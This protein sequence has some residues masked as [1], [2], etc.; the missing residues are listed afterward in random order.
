MVKCLF[1][2][3]FWD[4]ASQSFVPRNSSFTS[5]STNSFVWNGYELVFF[6]SSGGIFTEFVVVDDV[7]P[8]FTGLYYN[9]MQ[10][11]PGTYSVNGDVNLIA[12]YGAE[13]DFPDITNKIATIADL[14]S[15]CDKGTFSTSSLTNC[16]TLEAI[17]NMH[18]YTIYDTYSISVNGSYTDT[19]LVR[20]SDCQLVREDRK[21]YYI[22]IKS[23][24]LSASGTP[25]DQTGWE[26][27]NGGQFQK[28]FP[29]KIRFYKGSEIDRELSTSIM[30]YGYQSGS[31]IVALNAKL[32]NHYLAF[33][34]DIIITKIE[35]VSVDLGFQFGGSVQIDAANQGKDYTWNV[36]AHVVC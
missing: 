11:Q 21:Y 4:D 7:F 23:S 14:N 20:F 19:Q 10:I 30:I 1:Q 16:P 36:S 6:L 5:E 15:L 28:Q 31:S 2:Q 8:E 27:I 9:N 32:Q 17:K 13:P 33:P 34:K 35:L 26:T 3:L 29:V 25:T 12:Y 24:M 22:T 18:V